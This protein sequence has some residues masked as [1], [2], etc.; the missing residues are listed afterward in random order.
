MSIV[1]DQLSDLEQALTWSARAVES[2]RE[3]AEESLLADALIS[4]GIARSRA[5]DTAGGLAHFREALRL[6]E[7]AGRRQA[8]V[9]VLNNMGINCKNLGRLDE[10]IA[11]CGTRRRSSTVTPVRWRCC[12]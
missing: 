5:G 1:H 12:A 6:H 10:A 3:A 9:S 2:A 4:L 7:A 8:C 11:H